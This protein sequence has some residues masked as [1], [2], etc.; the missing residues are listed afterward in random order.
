MENIISKIREALIASA[1]E[2]TRNQSEYFFKE[3]ITVY[4]VK[5][6]TVQKIAKEIFAEI[7]DKPKAEIFEA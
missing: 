5:S 6:A 7:K 4:G 3:Q 1:D 2:K